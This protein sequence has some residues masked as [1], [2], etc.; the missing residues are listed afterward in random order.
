MAKLQILRFPDERLRTVAEPVQFFGDDVRE[1]V[2][3]MFETMY[4]STPR[5]I[6]LAATQ[7]DIHKQ[8]VTIDVSR[9]KDEPMVLINPKITKRRGMVEMYEG[10]LSFPKLGTH[11]KR[12]M[13]VTVEALDSYGRAQTINATE[14]LA[15]CIQH[16]LDHLAGKLL[17]DYFPAGVRKR[18]EKQY[19]RKAK[20]RS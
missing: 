19:F 11:V 2:D 17:I 5:G 8:I 12:A 9:F 7:V 3:N 13:C 10:C 15:I 20:K 14:L 1:I 6:G 4:T 18:L 16:E